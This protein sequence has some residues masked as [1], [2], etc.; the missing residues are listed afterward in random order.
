[1]DD[2]KSQQTD[3]VFNDNHATAS[4]VGLQRALTLP[5]PER[6]SDNDENGDEEGFQTFVLG[7]N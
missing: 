3:N 2:S 7:Y 6:R 1:M 5:P 4:E